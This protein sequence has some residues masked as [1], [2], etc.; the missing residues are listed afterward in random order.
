MGGL[1]VIVALYLPN[2]SQHIREAGHLLDKDRAPLE[3]APLLY[4]TEVDLDGFVCYPEAEGD[5]KVFED[6]LG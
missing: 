1:V 6:I 2:G 5:T 3:L 4:S